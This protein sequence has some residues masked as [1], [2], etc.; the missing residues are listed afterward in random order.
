MFLLASIRSSKSCKLQSLFV[1]HGHKLSGE[2][3]LHPSG[4][5]IQAVRLDLFQLS[6]KLVLQTDRRNL[7]YCVLLHLLI[8]LLQIK[9]QNILKGVPDIENYIVPVVF[10]FIFSVFLL[11]LAVL[12]RL[13][14]LILKGCMMCVCV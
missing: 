4:L 2:F 1:H 6:L 9:K 12:I 10:T 14:Y 11:L 7:K 5:N 8:T 13:S 3:N